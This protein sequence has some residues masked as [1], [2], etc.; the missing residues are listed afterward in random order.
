MTTC[1][2]ESAINKSSNANQP[3]A[4]QNR[5]NIPFKWKFQRQ[6][7]HQ[8]QKQKDKRGM[9]I[10]SLQMG[11]CKSQNNVVIMKDQTERQ[12][13][14]LRRYTHCSRCIVCAKGWDGFLEYRRLTLSKHR[15]QLIVSAE[16]KLMALDSVS[17]R[18]DHRCLMIL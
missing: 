12:M 7:T 11:A 17:F 8:V 9:L 5:S 13:A 18:L 10:H 3:V 1:P 6:K 2:N 16:G 15:I 4:N 14:Y